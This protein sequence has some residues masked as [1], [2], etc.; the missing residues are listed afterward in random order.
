MLVDFI[1]NNNNNLISEYPTKLADNLLPF[2]IMIILI[3]SR[4]FKESETNIRIE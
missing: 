4:S 1:Q 2:Q 3:F